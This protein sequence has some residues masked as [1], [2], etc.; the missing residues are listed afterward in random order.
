M[1]PD[2][3]FSICSSIAM[4]GWLLLIIVS[5]FWYKIDSFIIG[6]IVTVFAIVYTWLI[7]ANFHFSDIEKFNTLDGVMSLFSNKTIVTAG[8]IHY[9]AFDLMTGLW[10]KKNSEKHF[11]SHWLVIPCLLLTFMFGPIGLLIYL[12]LRSIVTK[13]Y[14]AE[15]Y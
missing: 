14:F 13:Q 9:L 6:I 5:Q 2:L 8:W 1:T 12:L 7:F 10:I 3:I 15:N 11:I 4:V